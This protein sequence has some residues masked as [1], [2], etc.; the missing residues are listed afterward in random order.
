MS[1]VL[2]PTFEP[3]LQKTRLLQVVWILTSDW[4]E[5]RGSQK[6]A[7][8]GSYVTCWKTSLPGWAVRLATY[9]DFAAKSTTTFR[10]KVLQPATN[11]VDARQALTWLV[12]GATSLFNS[13]CNNVA[14]QVARF[15]CPI[16]SPSGLALQGISWTN[17]IYRVTAHVF[18]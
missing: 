6:R 5:L 1:G 13:F 7:P 17:L 2:P 4:M 16:Y 8:D 9:T 15:C 10:N 18:N 3:V 14:K 11:W 12:K